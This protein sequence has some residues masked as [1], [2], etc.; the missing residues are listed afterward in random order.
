MD[1][2]P[3]LHSDRAFQPGLKPRLHI[4][5]WITPP[6]PSEFLVDVGPGLHSDRA[7]QP[8]LKPRLH[9]EQV[10]HPPPEP[11]EFLVDVGPGL[12]TGPGPLG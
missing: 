6:E 1:V 8:G 5:P 12:Q 11:S 2:G 9:I 7:L 4:E 3:G 10:G